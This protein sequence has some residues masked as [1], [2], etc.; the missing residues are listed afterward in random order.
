MI[1]GI[2]GQTL[3]VQRPGG[4]NRFGD[5]LPGT[6]FLSPGWLLA[7]AGTSEH[8]EGG[9]QVIDRLTAYGP[10]DADVTATDRIVLSDG[11]RW[12]IVGQ[13]QR[14]RTPFAGVVFSS[15]DGLCALTL[16]RVTG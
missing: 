15:A 7:P 16:E 8:T 12:Q 5:P 2:A 13:P 4:T 6:E 9:E 11:S 1:G 3:T 10:V 14:Y